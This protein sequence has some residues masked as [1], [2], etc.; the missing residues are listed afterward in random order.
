MIRMSHC[1]PSLARLREARSGGG[2]ALMEKNMARLALVAAAA[3]LLTSTSAAGAVLAV[4]SSGPFTGA[5]PAEKAHA[6]R[7]LTL[8]ANDIAMLIDMFRP[9]GRIGQTP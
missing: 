8:M 2:V 9:L 6:Q 1:R 4:R 7:M 5:V 3:A